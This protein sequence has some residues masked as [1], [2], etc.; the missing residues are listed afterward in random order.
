MTAASPAA[1]DAALTA[2]EKLGGFT[3]LPER[4]LR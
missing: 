1:V 2:L 4:K 3:C